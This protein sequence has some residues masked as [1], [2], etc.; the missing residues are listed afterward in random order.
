MRRCLA[1]CRARPVQT[2]IRRSAGYTTGTR[3]MMN[4]APQ[5]DAATSDA[6]QGVWH[7]PGRF[8]LHHGGSLEQ[9]KLGWRLDGAS[10]APIVVALGGISA[11]RRVFDLQSP[12]EGWWSG[13]AGPR[14]AL[15]S[16]RVRV[17]G[18]DYLGASGQ[19]SGPVAGG[20]F[21]SLSSYDQ[22]Q[23]LCGLID[24][25][26]IARLRAIVGAS[27]GGMVALAF[28]E[29]YPERVEQLLVLSAADRTHPMATAWRSI[30]RRIVRFALSA[31]RPA[32]GLELARALAMATYRSPQEFAARFAFAPSADE[33]RFVFPVEQYLMARGRDYA[34]RYLPESFLCL[35][36]SIDL[37]AVDAQRISVP[38]TLVAVRE[39]QLVPLADMQALAARMPRARLYELSSA[40]G[41]D[42]FLKEAAQ[43]Q[44]IFQC[45][46]GESPK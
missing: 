2:L 22:A 38:S 36:E 15:D 43:L 29:R 14:R 3:S 23:G 44:P 41:H 1:I 28:A 35:S 6:S 25:L 24:H 40:N 26:Q 4:F 45:L 42:G 19:S 33:S 5:V 12:A 10:E 37:H 9:V 32:E 39:D 18:I 46:Y 7:W 30:Q 21:P 17:L 13:L 27:Y 20:E 31:G 34:A 11:H 16:T 8:A